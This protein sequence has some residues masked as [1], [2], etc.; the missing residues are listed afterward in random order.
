[1][2]D[3][4]ILPPG[5]VMVPIGIIFDHNMQPVMRDT[6]IQL[7]ALA[8]ENMRIATASWQQFIKMTNKSRSV[9]YGHLCQLKQDGLICAYTASSGMLWV[10][11]LS[12]RMIAY[13]PRKCPDP[14]RPEVRTKF[15]IKSPNFRT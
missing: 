10:E 11:F 8:G 13:L 9:L 14:N 2:S 12:Q 3:E 6:Y 15:R 5:P 4:L 1:M 7:L